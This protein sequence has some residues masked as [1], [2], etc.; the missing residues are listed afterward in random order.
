MVVIGSVAGVLV[1]KKPAKKNYLKK[2]RNYIARTYH[3]IMQ[4]WGVRCRLWMWMIV[5]ASIVPACFAWDWVRAPRRIEAARRALKAEDYHAAERSARPLLRSLAHDLRQTGRLL[6]AEALLH[7]GRLDECMAQVNR[8]P[9]E[10]VHTSEAQVLLGEVYLARQQPLRAEAIFR[11][12]LDRW[13]DEQKAHRW[14]AAIYYDLGHNN[15]VIEHLDRLEQLCPEDP[16]PR[17][18]K[19]VIHMDSERYREAASSYQEALR[20]EPSDFNSRLG[21]ADALIR[22]GEVTSAELH[23]AQC[24]QERLDDPEVLVLRAECLRSKGALDEAAALLDQVLDVN[25]QH[26]R[27]LLGRAKLHLEM[28]QPEAALTAL[29]RI[30]QAD[31]Y[32]WQ[33]HYL[34]GLVHVRLGKTEQAEESFEKV[35]R[36]QDLMRQLHQL[37]EAAIAR[38]ND[39][40]IRHRLG[41]VCVELGKAEL[42]EMWFRAALMLDPQ[43]SPTHQ[44]LADFYAQSGLHERA[45]WH[46]ARAGVRAEVANP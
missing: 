20:C 2:C 44:S 5:L 33:A 17:V 21:L 41:Q 13:P 38:P 14:L 6:L 7:Q 30:L 46:T 34:S 26:T 9:R 8:L 32:D 43:H 40:N 28:R 18:L 15:G 19:A 10:W 23:L 39:P 29:Q 16:K 27:A 45:D 37:N 31:A 1:N 24:N 25:E 11:S 12:I 4:L 22:Q 35:R 3:N 42:A 36:S